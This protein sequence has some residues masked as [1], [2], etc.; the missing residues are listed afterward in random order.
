MPAS[1]RRIREN[2]R[3][4]PIARRPA[5]SATSAQEI[6]MSSARSAIVTGAGQGI[7]YRFAQELGAQGFSLIVAD[8]TGAEEAAARLRKASVSCHGIRTDVSSEA[9]VRAMAATCI[10]RFGG[11]DVLVNNA[12]LM[13]TL[14]PFEEISSDEWMKVMGVNTLGPFL[15]AK[16][17]VPSMR[18][19]GRGRIV[20][21]ASTVALKG[22]PGWLHYVSSKGA[23]IA[24]T[25]ALAREVGQAGITVNAIAP[26][27]TLSDG[28][29]ESNLHE[30][31]GENARVGGR[32]I[33]RDQVPDDLVGTL[34][35]L[36]G[37]GASFVTGQTIVVDGG[38]MF[39]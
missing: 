32:S 13:S 2:E 29:L 33:Q 24:F 28:I 8:I 7:G 34:L 16:A 31:I 35:Y 9:D 26:G 21:L 39:V 20:N 25:R 23:V 10:E 18:E 17:V 38:S 19:K 37:D 12:G 22:V 1:L 30:V 6:A 5:H 14:R 27:F 4:G 15:C 11:I 3:H 36:V